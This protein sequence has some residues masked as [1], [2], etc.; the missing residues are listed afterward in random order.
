MRHMLLLRRM[1]TSK[2]H[3]QHH[4]HESDEVRLRQIG[5][6]RR[7]QKDGHVCRASLRR[8]PSVESRRMCALQLLRHSAFS[9]KWHHSSKHLLI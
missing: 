4:G 2:M 1:P 3:R 7:Y 5:V 6:R 9:I 8:K